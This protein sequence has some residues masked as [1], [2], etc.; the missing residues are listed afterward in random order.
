MSEDYKKLY[1]SRQERMIGGVCGG[2]AEY[3]GIDPTLIRVA[4]VVFA[5]AG[6]PGFVAYIIMLLIVTEEPRAPEAV[7]EAVETAESTT[8]Q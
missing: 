2:I 1:R 6:G 5:L 7:V 4:F 3:F 8:G